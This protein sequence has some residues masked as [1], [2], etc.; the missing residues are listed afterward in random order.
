MS[1]RELQR[2]EALSKVLERRFGRKRLGAE[3][4]PRSAATQ[5]IKA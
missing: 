3:C 4:P 5:D 2:L 1:D